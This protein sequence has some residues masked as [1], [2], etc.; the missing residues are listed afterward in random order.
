[1][2]QI[3]ANLL[4]RLEEA[5]EQGWLGEVAA[6]ETTMAAAVQKLEAMRHPQRAGRPRHA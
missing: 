1:M 5:K 2:E 4:D 3:H 6:I